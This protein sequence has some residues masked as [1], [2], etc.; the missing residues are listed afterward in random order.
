MQGGAA[1]VD[2]GHGMQALAGQQ[3]AWPA[4]RMPATRVHTLLSARTRT[5]THTRTYVAR[6]E[7]VGQAARDGLH[8]MHEVVPLR[9]GARAR[10]RVRVTTA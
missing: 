3:H 6:D 5:H 7:H 1:R 8:L 4:A 2:G 10:V 9:V